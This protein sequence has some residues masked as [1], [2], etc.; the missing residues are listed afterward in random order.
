MF[1]HSRKRTTAGLIALALAG[2]AGVSAYAFT[3]SNT[4]SDA[5]AN[6]GAGYFTV[7]GYDVTNVNYT[8]DVTGSY[9]LA[10]NF[11]LNAPAGAVDV[12]LTTGEPTASDWYSC[13]SITDVSDTDY[14]VTC[15][16]TGTPIGADSAT[17][18]GIAVGNGDHLSVIATASNTITV[19][20]T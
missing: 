12:A 9:Y 3:A 1:I 17:A 18:D 19:N 13:G 5:S 2:V 8:F 10:V 20:G 14:D 6:S 16:F 11:K 7:S 15:S 4:N